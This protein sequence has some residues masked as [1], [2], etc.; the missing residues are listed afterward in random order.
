[1]EI[2]GTASGYEYAVAQ[3]QDS[4]WFCDVVFFGLARSY[5]YWISTDARF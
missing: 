4:D 2:F 5:Y 3:M 1:M